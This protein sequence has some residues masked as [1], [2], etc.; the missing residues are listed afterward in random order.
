MIKNGGTMLNSSMGS[1]MFH[2]TKSS[3]RGSP[4]QKKRG[5]A[6]IDQAEME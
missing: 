5:A 2:S 1:S 3:T 6:K 4:A